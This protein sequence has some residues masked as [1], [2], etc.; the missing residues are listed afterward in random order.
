MYL[1]RCALLH[2][3]RIFGHLKVQNNYKVPCTAQWPEEMWGLK[4][5]TKDLVTF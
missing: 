2:F 3:E 4:L 1:F 5:G